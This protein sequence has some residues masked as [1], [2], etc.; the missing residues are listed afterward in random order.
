MAIRI[1]KLRRFERAPRPLTPCTITS[2]LASTSRWR[3]TPARSVSGL[4]LVELLVA[5][6]VA[7]M[8][9]AMVV[10]VFDQFGDGVSKT[11][12]AMNVQEQLRHARDIVQNDLD[13]ISAKMYGP[14]VTEIT[15][16]PAHDRPAP[17]TSS[18]MGDPDDWFRISATDG[19]NRFYPQLGQS[20]ASFSSPFAE[21]VYFVQDGVLYR[22]VRVIAPGAVVNNVSNAVLAST[23]SGR[24]D[25]SGNFIFNSLD[26]LANRRYR[27]GAT[28]TSTFP[29]RVYTKALAPNNTPPTLVPLTGPFRG[30]DALLNNV[31]SFDIKVLDPGAPIKGYGSGTVGVSSNFTPG[32]TGSTTTGGTATGGTTSG[33]TTSGGTTSG[34]T[35]TGGISCDQPSTPIIDNG[36]SGFTNTSAF[37]LRATPTPPG[38]ETDMHRVKAA[39]SGTATW[40]FTGLTA[41]ATYDIWVTYPHSTG[42]ATDAPYTI[43][44]GSTEIASTTVNQQDAP[45]GLSTTDDGGTDWTSLGTHTI[46]GTTLVIE[47]SDSPTNSGVVAAD[48]IFIECIGG[49]G[50]SGATSGSTTSGTTTG[51]TTS[52]GTTTGGGTTGGTTSGGGTT[53][54]STT[55]TVAPYAIGP[56]DYGYQTTMDDASSDTLGFGGFVDLYNYAQGHTPAS[57]L[58]NGPGDLKSQLHVVTAATDPAVFDTWSLAYERDG[59]D[60]DSS[61]DADEG[62]N[63]LDDDGSGVVDD[64][65]ERD[66]APPYATPPRA[67]EITIRVF[68]PAS[69]V[70]RQ[71][72]IRQRLDL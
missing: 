25:E 23:F 53:G 57:A 6:A 2:R 36:D 46:T 49:G 20:A 10:T 18:V 32:T 29:H 22:Q 35:T 30:Q 67:I 13:N 40:T 37:G 12:S 42:R 72:T 8:L 38:Y 33:G 27:A 54:G 16:G 61:G 11:N 68:D 60:Q 48:A 7:M 28:S 59:I 45:S 55:G 4:T 15:E 63:G 58:F 44:D 41:G 17:G 69:R 3:R 14:G 24:V 26:D 51:G 31:V 71:A 50:G 9:L 21:I 64:A 66:T 62:F 34:G 5:T 43:F 56:G 65:S 1:G 70:T 39:D 47:V 19:E 52:G